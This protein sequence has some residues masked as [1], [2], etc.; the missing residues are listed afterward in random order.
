MQSISL[1]RKSDRSINEL[2]GS[3]TGVGLLLDR[4]Y[5]HDRQYSDGMNFDNLGHWHGYK[6]EVP[7]CNDYRLE[8]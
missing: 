1:G 7:E 8:P 5:N 4:R 6:V 3:N 2:D